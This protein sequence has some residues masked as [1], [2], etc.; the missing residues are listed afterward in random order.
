M[1]NPHEAALESKCERIARIITRQY[2]VKVKIEG[3][4]AY[5]DLENKVIVLPHMKGDA[6]EHVAGMIDGFLD[7]ECSHA[8]FTDGSLVIDT[9]KGDR[10][11]WNFW[12]VIE[13]SWVE[14]E[15]GKRFI[16]CGQNLRRL[17]EAVMKQNRE[18][19]DSADGIQKLATAMA[20]CWR[21][22]SCP[23]DFYGDPVVGDLLRALDPEVQAGYKI[24]STQG[25][26]D[27]AR[28]ILD[29]IQSMS[30]PPPQPQGSEENQPEEGE[31]D[32]QGQGSG[33]AEGEETG[34]DKNDQNSKGSEGQANSSSQ[35]P[36]EAPEGESECQGMDPQQQSVQEQAQA[37]QAAIEGGDFGDFKDAE[38][39]M[40]DL[41]SEVPDRIRDSDPEEYY[42]FSEEYDEET[43][44]GDKDRWDWSD[45]YRELRNEISDYL[46]S[47]ATTLELALAAEAQARW[48]GGSRRG[49]K[50]DKRAF[51][52]WVC[53]SRDDRI[54]RQKEQHEAW[55]V[56]VSL[57][58]DCSGSMQRFRPGSPSYLARLAA[59]A[60]H[61]ALTRV[62]I[63]H[64]V[65]GFNTGGT[66][67]PELT[68]RVEKAK[69]QGEDLDRYSRLAERDQRMVF[70]PWGAEDG[71]AICAINGRSAN[72]DGEC[73]MWAA[74]R[75]AMRPEKRKVL[76]VGSDGRPNGARYGYTEKKYL[77]EVVG[78]VISAGIELYAIGIMDDNVKKYYPHHLTINSIEELPGAVMHQLAQALFQRQGTNHGYLPEIRKPGYR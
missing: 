58:W 12:N 21:G 15:M 38:D 22:L 35:E 66:S 2:G 45:E 49:R 54:Y 5:I 16:G 64:E 57:L 42:V 24:T 33:D 68:G 7:H 40:N 47:I 52:A 30:P 26:L 56:A 20:E 50:F 29:K 23:D 9:A 61:E 3:G 55:D 62:G 11:L 4:R 72:R 8:I 60:F 25:A 19:W 69:D 46:G 17:N 41:L 63:M 39:L 37:L 28:R 18:H 51:P 10:A 34:N 78:Q 59:I 75:L 43:H 65:L 6:L 76:I 48:V 71:R 27:L 14:R 44:Y 32:G 67:H 1:L 53:G 74:K 31:G 13:D 36:Q 73:V 70:V 77:Q